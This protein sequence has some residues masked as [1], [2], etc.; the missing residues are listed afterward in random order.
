MDLVY[1]RHGQ[2]D[3]NVLGRIQGRTDIPLNSVGIE[4]AELAGRILAKYRFDAVY[5]SPL[6]RTRQTLEHACPGTS[7]IYDPRLLEWSFG[8]YE[9]KIVPNNIFGKYWKIGCERVEG[10]ELI[11]DVINRAS[12]F[13]S[14][15][16]EK[17]GNERV[18]VVSHGGFSAALYATVYG[19]NAE[20]SLSKYCLPNST[21]VLFREGQAPLILKEE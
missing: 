14:E 4:G 17:H 9:G 5:C 12:S 20:E 1:L 19:V 10:M 11:E 15:I 13:Y 2:T 16:K 6:T 3:W 7:A 21:P 8:P 18:L